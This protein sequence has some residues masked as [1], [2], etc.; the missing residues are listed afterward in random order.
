MAG[1]GKGSGHRGPSRRSGEEGALKA[2]YRAILVER[3]TA[4]DLAELQFSLRNRFDEK[5]NLDPEYQEKS[6]W[7][8]RTRLHEEILTREITGIEPLIRSLEP[9]DL[10]KKDRGG[11]GGILTGPGPARPGRDP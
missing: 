9:G 11:E 5:G 2:R 3:L 10:K 6:E 1:K 4:A 7:K 8:L